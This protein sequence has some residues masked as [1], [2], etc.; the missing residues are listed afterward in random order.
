MFP[1]DIITT[2]VQT[3]FVRFVNVKRTRAKSKYV[4]KERWERWRA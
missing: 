2:P 3:R 1:S 4:E